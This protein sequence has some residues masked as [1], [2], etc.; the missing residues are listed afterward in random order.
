MAFRYHLN[1]RIDNRIAKDMKSVLRTLSNTAAITHRSQYIHNPLKQEY[2][3]SEISQLKAKM[4]NDDVVG[5][6]HHHWAMCNNYYPVERQDLQHAL[7]TLLCAGISAR[8]GTIIESG[9]YYD[10]NDVLKYKD[11]KVHLV[12]N[13]QDPSRKM[14]VMLITFR[15]IKGYRNCGS[16]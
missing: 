13:P 8:P 7:L 2:E 15:L 14:V 1:R 11:I 3:L 4:N 16:P 12:R 10:E 5:M 6:L 9:R